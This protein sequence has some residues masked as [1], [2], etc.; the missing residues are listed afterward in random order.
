MHISIDSLI[1]ILSVIVLGIFIYTFYDNIFSTLQKPSNTNVGV[2]YKFKLGL[3]R[4]SF[5]GPIS[6]FVKTT[7]VNLTDDDLN[8]LL[9]YVF[10]Q[11]GSSNEIPAALLQ[12]L[13]LYTSTVIQYLLELGYIII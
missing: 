10:R 3:M 11:I 7:V 12:S 5:F 13:G 1:F 2:F 6:S 9:E 8:T 4:L